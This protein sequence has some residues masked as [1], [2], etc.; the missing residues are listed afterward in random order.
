FDVPP[1]LAGHAVLIELYPAFARPDSAPPW[2]A[3]ARVR[4]FTDSLEAVGPPRPLTVVAGGRAVLQR[5]S[6][7]P[8]MLPH[9][10]VPLVAWQLS[11][12]GDG[13][14]APALGYQEARRP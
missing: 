6:G 10:F 8:M 14:G 7:S 1:A 11:P 5:A 3:T 9:G 4:F 12:S 13:R 2:R